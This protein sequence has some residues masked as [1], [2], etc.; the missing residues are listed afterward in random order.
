M[1]PRW[2]ILLTLMLTGL[3]GGATWL[4]AGLTEDPTPPSGDGLVIDIYGTTSGMPMVRKDPIAV[5]LFKNTGAEA[6]NLGLSL[7][8]SDLIAEDMRM[9]GRFDVIDRSMYVENPH[10]AGVKPGEFDFNDWKVIG[11]EYLIKGNFALDGGKLTVQ[12]RLYHVP[13]QKML[14]GKEYSGKPD[15]WYLM[16]HKF[17]NDVV[18]ELTRE[19]GIFGTKV[20]YASTVGGAQEIFVIDVDGRNQKRLTYLGGKAKNPTW[21]PDGSQ[22]AFAWENSANVSDM[23][24]SLYVVPTTGGEPKLLLKIKGIL[25]TTRFS[26]SG[27]R[28][29][30]AI[31]YDGN[32]E[33]YTVSANGGKPKRL[34]VAHGIEI[35]PA[36]SPSGDQIAFV[37]DRSGGPQIWR[38]KSDGSDPQRVSYFGSYN[39][40][41]DWAKTTNGDRIVYSSRESGIFNILMV[42]PEGT[43]ATVITQGQGFGSCEYPSFSPDGRA[44]ALTSNNGSGRM[45]RLF[46]VDGSYT[47]QLTRPGTDDKNSAWSPR[48]L[49]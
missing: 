13:T 22:I 48:L 45:L 32:M 4:A 1:R 44:I 35:F 21:S 10:A 40:S 2:A 46:N 25:I 42:T 19:K 38:M 27:S 30:M 36:W 49:N 14:V 28:I 47:K 34:T 23:Y 41:P 39:M 31:S 3:L 8:L 33:I 26:P 16:V 11:A 5:P 20:A 7:K 9:T 18:Y 37:S 24:N 43:D 6:D 15:D 29:A 17:G 12:F